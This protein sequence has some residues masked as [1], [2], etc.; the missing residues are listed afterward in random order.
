MIPDKLFVP[1]KT[2]AEKLQS[3]D[4]S[5]ESCLKILRQE[6]RKR[7]ELTYEASEHFHLADMDHYLRGIEHSF[8]R[9]TT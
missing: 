9:L 8:E 5:I 1:Q 3:I 6:I 2:E 4:S 7:S